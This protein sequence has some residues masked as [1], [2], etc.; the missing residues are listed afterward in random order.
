MS[1]RGEVEDISGFCDDVTKAQSTLGQRVLFGYVPPA[2]L[3]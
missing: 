1:N 2:S 3:E